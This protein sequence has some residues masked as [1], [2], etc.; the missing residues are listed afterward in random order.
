MRFFEFQNTNADIDKFVIAL[1]NHIGR[2]ASKRSAAT[3]NWNAI[4][5]MSRANG[6]EFAAD[7]ET[8]K[9]MYDAN[10]VLQS[11][12]KNFNDR[13]IEL[14]VPGAPDDKNPP[15]TQDSEEEVA[16]I[17]ASA[18]PQQLAQNQ[19]GVQA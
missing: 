12:V 19:Q 9:A 10:P 1:K 7:Y 8:F 17:A 5:S 6:F 3:L 11:M 16:K 15:G 2:A 18:A 14:N 13:G 4:A